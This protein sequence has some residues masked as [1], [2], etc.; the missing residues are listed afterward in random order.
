MWNLLAS[1][2]TVLFFCQKRVTHLFQDILCNRWDC[3]WL[4]IVMVVFKIGFIESKILHN[5]LLST[6]SGLLFIWKWN[7]NNIQ[8]RV[9]FVN[10]PLCSM[11]WRTALKLYQ[12]YIRDVM[13]PVTHQSPQCQAVLIKA[14]HLYN[15]TGFNTVYTRQVIYNVCSI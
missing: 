12:I 3:T 6:A 8:F 13:I 7:R 11:A 4:W 9:D 2:L 10:Q 14:M 15:P 5:F 1:N